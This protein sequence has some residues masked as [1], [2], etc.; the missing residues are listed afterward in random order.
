ML[1]LPAMERLELDAHGIPTGARAPVAPS[2]APLAERVLD[3]GFAS[4]SRFEL[5]GG[6]RRIEVELGHGYPFAQV[7]APSSPAVVALEPMTAPANALSSGDDLRLVEPGD[8]FVATF[9]ILVA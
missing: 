3:D 8:R 4:P 5:S 6:G 2:S 9:R 1:T 7:F